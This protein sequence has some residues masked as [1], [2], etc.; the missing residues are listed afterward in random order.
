MKETGFVIFPLLTLAAVG[1]FAAA[2][3]A[4]PKYLD[5]K[6]VTKTM[7]EWTKALGV[8]CDYCHTSDR[9][10]SFETLGGKT[11]GAKELQALIN[12]RVAK[13]M[14]GNMLYVNGK[15][16]SNQTCNTCHQ[17]KAKV[18]VK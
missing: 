6:D 13:A 5:K 7:I 8:K 11:A 1:Y 2:T 3:Q 15:M 12:Q 16:A 4:E 14:L 9:A 10:Q 17:G 18:A